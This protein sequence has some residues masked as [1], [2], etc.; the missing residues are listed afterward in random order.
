[1]IVDCLYS[2]R[3][4][5]VPPVDRVVFK[6]LLQKAT[7]GM[8]MYK[9]ILYKQVDGVA[10]GS[11]L[12]PSLANFFLGHIEETKIFQN[13]D[14]FP[15]VYLRY[16]DDIFAV[17]EDGTTYHPFFKLLN[18]QHRNLKFTVD[19]ADGSFPFLNVDI[20]INGTS[21]DTWVFRKKTHTGVMLNF[22]AIVPNFW[23]TG[24]IKCM[25]NSGK[26]I[27]SSEDLFNK[28]VEKLRKMFAANGY[29]K[30]FFD[31]TLE[32]FSLSKNEVK[33]DAD[34]NEPTD[35]RHIFGIP[36]VG[37]ISREYKQKVTELIKQHLE[38][39]ISSY[40]TSC[41]VSSFFS[42]KS[43]TPFALK[44]R[45][46]YQYTCLSDS[47]TYYIGKSK[48]HL[49]TRAKEHVNPKESNQ[50]EVK[51]HIFGCDQCKKSKLSLESFSI[52]KQCKDDYSARISEAL[53]IKKLRPKINN[54]KLTD[55]YLLRVF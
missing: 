3:S 12:G 24:L 34:E 55:S 31:R 54:Q 49:V 33:S 18:E 43:S 40:Y 27:C 37:N 51:K 19:E 47:D 29:P 26:M 36:W 13:G 35:R 45:V 21:V 22:S 42:L 39:D 8:F 32:K 9:N 14:I 48:R 7:G 6:Q 1:M 2:E 28:E 50:S 23:K 41:K 25:L 46:V 53:M 5:K 20:E 44:A 10:M 52:K 4:K 38:V 17:F 15:I 11:P 30:A 16:V